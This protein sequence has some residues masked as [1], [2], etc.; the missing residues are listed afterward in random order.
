MLRPYLARNE[1]LVRELN[2]NLDNPLHRLLR[3]RLLDEQLRRN[4]TPTLSFIKACKL[5]NREDL[6]EEC[7]N[8]KQ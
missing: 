3:E 5:T 7:N 2:K 1:E 4:T 8:E 6:H